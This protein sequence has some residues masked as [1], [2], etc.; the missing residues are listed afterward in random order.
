LVERERL[1]E[2]EP[3]L[4]G[5]AVLDHTGP[6]WIRTVLLTLRW[7]ALGALGASERGS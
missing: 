7:T 1:A 4:G 3:A 5:E 2:G 6:Q